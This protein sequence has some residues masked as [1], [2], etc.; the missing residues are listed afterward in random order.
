M[1]RSCDASHQSPPVY[2]HAY[3]TGNSLG[4]SRVRERRVFSARSCFSSL[5]TGGCPTT[6]GFRSFSITGHLRLQ[7]PIPRRFSSRLLSAM[8]GRRSGATAFTTSI[9]TTPRPTRF[10][11]LHAGMRADA[12]RGRW[13]RSLRTSGRRSRAAYRDRPLQPG[14]QRRF[15]GGWRVPAGPALGRLPQRA[16]TLRSGADAAARVSGF[17]SRHRDVGSTSEALALERIDLAPSNTLIRAASFFGSPPCPVFIQVHLKKEYRLHQIVV[18]SRPPILR[19]YSN[20]GI[21]AREVS[22]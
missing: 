14:K 21:P 8:A 20:K 12:W 19:E 18:D 16:D 22:Y 13:P 5:G 6:S 11:D 2:R 7:S 10:W 1:L 3:G 4:S 15:S 9:T 17:R